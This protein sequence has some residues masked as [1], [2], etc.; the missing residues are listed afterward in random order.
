MVRLILGATVDGGK[1]LKGCWAHCGRQAIPKCGA[2]RHDHLIFIIGQR[3]NAANG[4]LQ[5]VDIAR[6]VNFIFQKMMM[7]CLGRE[8]SG[9]RGRHGDLVI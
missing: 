5:R 6:W 9:L 7:R 4:I 3:E 8:C 2:E 1:I